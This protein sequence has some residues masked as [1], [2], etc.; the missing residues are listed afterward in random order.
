M[1]VQSKSLE[2]PSESSTLAHYY[3]SN[4]IFTHRCDKNDNNS[5]YFSSNQFSS[6]VIHSIGSRPTD[7]SQWA[8]SA[9]L[10]PYPIGY[11]ILPMHELIKPLS[12]AWISG[13]NIGNIPFN[14]N[15]LN[16]EKLNSTLIKDF[17]LEYTEKYCEIILETPNGDCPSYAG[18]GCGLNSNCALEEYCQNMDNSEGFVCKKRGCGPNSCTSDKICENADNREGFVCMVIEVPE[19]PEV[20]KLPDRPDRP[21]CC[22]QVFVN[23]A[24]WQ[25]AAY[26]LHRD[27]FDVYTRESYSLINGRPHWTNGN[28]DI[29][30]AANGNWV[31]GSSNNRGSTTGS[32]YTE[33]DVDCVHDVP[34]TSWKYYDSGEWIDAGTNTIVTCYEEGGGLTETAWNTFAD[35][36][37]GPAV[38]TAQDFLQY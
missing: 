12:E 1:E 26:C 16:G 24:P 13:G 38:C 15:D 6:T 23:F 3:V 29:W 5:G 34:R 10:T 19:D 25:T 4:I 33:S 30:F 11:T 14:S 32:F 36:F 2:N 20:P 7:L 31:I 28:N 9:E 21:E 22:P 37:F 27:S 8:S 17:F 18:K 35:S